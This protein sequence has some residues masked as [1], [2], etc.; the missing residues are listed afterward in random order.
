MHNN[1]SSVRVNVNHEF[2]HSKN[3]I[4]KTVNRCFLDFFS[5]NMFKV[6]RCVYPIFAVPEVVVV[7][8]V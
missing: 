1:V 4:E 2:L 6:F 8:F 7:S 3:K 5:T